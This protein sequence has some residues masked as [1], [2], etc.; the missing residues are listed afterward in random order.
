MLRAACGTRPVLRR[1][2]ERA[3]EERPQELASGRIQQ[4]PSGLRTARSPDRHRPCV[5]VECKAHR[6]RDQFAALRA[7]K[8]LSR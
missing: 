7:E 4:R 2:G 1:S 3:A 6:L 8:R 5:G